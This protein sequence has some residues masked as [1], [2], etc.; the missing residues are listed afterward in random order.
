M[1]DVNISGVDSNKFDDAGTRITTLNDS[2]SEQ[3]EIINEAKTS[4]DS[5]AVF[6]GPA[7]DS[8]MEKL[9]EVYSNIELITDHFTTIKSYIDQAIINYNNAD[10]DAEQLFLNIKDNGSIEIVKGSPLVVTGNKTQDEVYAFLVKQ[11][12]NSAVISGIMANIAVESAGFQVAVDGDGGTSYG[13]CQ[14]HDGRKTKLKNYCKEN[15][16]DVNSVEGQMRYMMYE[17]ENGYNDSVYEKLKNIPD[18]KQGAYDAASI[19]T[20]N[21]EVPA[22]VDSQ[23]AYRGKSASSKYW[24]L[25]GNKKST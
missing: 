21:Y 11:G 5:D 17:L 18:T 19:W 6:A 2:L 16:L 25:Y 8:C 3:K 13:L 9:T 20:Y 10:K 4:L 7:A 22:N 12:F 23:A 24:D 1:P 14:W 15:N